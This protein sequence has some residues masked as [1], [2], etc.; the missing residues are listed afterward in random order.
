MVGRTHMMGGIAA[1]LAIS[2]VTGY[3]YP[4]SISME[5][6]CSFGMFL[7]CAEAGALIPDIDKKQSTISHRHKI[8]SFISRL[9]FTHRGFTHSL[10]CMA[11][12]EI[13]L[14]FLSI[15]VPGIIRI[16]MLYGIMIGYLSH[17]FLDSL[18]PLG[19]PLLFPFHYRFSFAKIKTGGICEFLVFL[20]LV[21]ISV[22]QIYEI[23]KGL[24]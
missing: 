21:A 24:L 2:S 5:T 8:I 23:G 1:A 7:G 17:L 4:E 10:L 12:I 22:F 14:F 11:I 18:N 20:S 15:P 19:I 16:P 13:I 3:F 6:I 9:L